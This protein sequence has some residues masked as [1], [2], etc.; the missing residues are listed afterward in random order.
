M[1]RSSS[2]TPLHRLRRRSVPPSPLPRLIVRESRRAMFLGGECLTSFVFYSSSGPQ[3]SEAG[4]F[5]GTLP[6]YPDLGRCNAGTL[7]WIVFAALT[8]DL[9]RTAQARSKATMSILITQIAQ[10]KKTA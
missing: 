1:R 5:A 7:V 10:S 3:V 8:A 6:R 2:E 9:C 4:Y